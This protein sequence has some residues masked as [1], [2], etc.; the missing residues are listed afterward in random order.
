MV[1]VSQISTVKDWYTYQ[2]TPAPFLPQISQARVVIEEIEDEDAFPALNSL[3]YSS[4]GPALRLVEESDTLD[5]RVSMVHETRNVIEVDD[6]SDEE[7][8]DEEDDDTNG[9]QNNEEEVA[10][11]LRKSGH[12]REAP[13]KEVTCRCLKDINLMLRPPQNKGPGYK[14]CRLPLVLRTQLEWIAGFLYLYTQDKVSKQNKTT[15]AEGHWSNASLMAAATQQR[16][17]YH[18]RN[19][20]AWATALI[21]DR[22]ALPISNNGTLQNSR[23]DDED[24]TTDIALHLQS[25]GPYI[26]A[27]DVVCYTAI[28]EVRQRLKIKKAISPA[29]AKRWMRKMGYR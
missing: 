23:I 29:T 21:S 28:P 6:S 22:A 11:S 12:I 13:S 20:R 26:T 27:N 4:Q 8:S 9:G 24:V 7:S 15:G 19:L 17:I 10:N 18:A 1:I 16:G 5:L 3:P 2:N 25:R 14:Q